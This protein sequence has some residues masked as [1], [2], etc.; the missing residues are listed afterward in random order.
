M[1]GRVPTDAMASAGTR[2]G[3]FVFGSTVGFESETD[4]EGASDVFRRD[5][6]SED[7]SSPLSRG[8]Y[9]TSGWSSSVSVP[10]S[11]PECECESIVEGFE[12]STVVRIYSSDRPAGS[13]GDDWRNDFAAAASAAA[14]SAAASA[15]DMGGTTVM[16][17]FMKV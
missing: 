2:R 17:P 1:R 14:A 3:G 10:E 12:D 6:G 11:V 8:A 16:E 4:A 5:D 7:S 13:R 15:G 9:G